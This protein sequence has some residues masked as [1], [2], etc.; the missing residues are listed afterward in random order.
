MKKIGEG[1]GSEFYDRSF[2]TYMSTWEY[3]SF[4]FY[5]RSFSTYAKVS[6][7]LLFLTLWYAHLTVDIR[8]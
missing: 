5:D 8:G 1:K 6:E 7:K 4:K 2:S 3:M